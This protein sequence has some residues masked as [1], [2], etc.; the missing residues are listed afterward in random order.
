MSLELQFRS[1]GKNDEF[2]SLLKI[3]THLL[4]DF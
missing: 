4:A 3:N 2:Q 1:E